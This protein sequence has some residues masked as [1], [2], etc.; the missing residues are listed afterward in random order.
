M[1]RHDHDGKPKLTLEQAQEIRE[2]YAA[3]GHTYRSLAEDY[4]VSRQN[5][6][7][8]VQGRTWRMP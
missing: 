5:I 1:S 3:G 4:G 8:I 6:L 7:L 2:K